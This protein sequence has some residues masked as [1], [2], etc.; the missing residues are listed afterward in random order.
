MAIPVLNGKYVVALDW[1]S[2]RTGWLIST[3]AAC[4]TSGMANARRLTRGLS[5]A[6]F[7]PGTRDMFYV[8]PGS[9]ELH[10]ISLPD[11]SDRVVRKFPGLGIYFSVDRDGKEIAYTETYRKM[12]FVLVENVFD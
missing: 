7:P 5:F 6:T 12:R 2:T 4:S 10:H 9:R 3:A 1:H 11:G 8:P